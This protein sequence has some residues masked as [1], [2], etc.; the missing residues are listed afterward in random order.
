MSKEELALYLTY[1]FSAHFKPNNLKEVCM[2]GEVKIWSCEDAGLPVFSYGK[3]HGKSVEGLG[4]PSLGLSEIHVRVSQKD[5][6]AILNNESMSSDDVGVKQRHLLISVFKQISVQL[7]EYS[8]GFENDEIEK[9]I[10]EKQREID[11]LRKMVISNERKDK[12]Y[13]H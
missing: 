1:E 2:F 11:A 13:A 8:D 4:L 5:V 7:E 3:Y 9:M 6:M 12:V 10:K